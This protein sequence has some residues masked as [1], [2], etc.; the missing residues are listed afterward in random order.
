MNFYGFSLQTVGN[1]SCLIN[2]FFGISHGS[3]CYS[4]LVVVERHNFTLTCIPVSQILDKCVFIDI[5]L[6]HLYVGLAPNK[7]ESD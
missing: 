4:H 5:G 3:C 7:I 6:D 2:E 1:M